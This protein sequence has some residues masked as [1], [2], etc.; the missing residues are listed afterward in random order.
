MLLMSRSLSVKKLIPLILFLVLCAG[1]PLASFITQKAATSAHAASSLPYHEF[2]DGPYKVKG[3]Q[4]IGADGKQYI[5]HGI[6]RDGLE[7]TCTGGGY[8]DAAHLSLMGPGNTGNGNT[9]WF[10]N[11]VRINLAQ[12]MWFNGV[13]NQ[14][15]P[16]QYQATVKSVVDTLTAD[17][18]NVMIDLMWTDAN[19]QSPGGAQ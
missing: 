3:N 2:M 11:T 16:A 13:P 7:F 14:C 6:G 8:L 4:I 17:K 15:T 18:L 10:A 1:I 19:G 12:N 5:F 9:Y